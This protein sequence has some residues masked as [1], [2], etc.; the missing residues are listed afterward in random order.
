MSSLGTA[1]LAKLTCHVP[2]A[3]GWRATVTLESGEAPALGPATLTIADLA[4]PG[5]VVRSGLDAPGNPRAVLFGG[6]GWLAPLA[7][8]ASYQSA[9]G[10][11]L[12]TVLRDLATA[13]GETIV[14]PTEA[15]I[16]LAFGWPSASDATPSTG[17]LVLNRLVEDGSLATW[18]VAPTGSTRFDAWPTSRAPDARYRVVSRDLTVG[19]RRL[20]LDTQAAAFLPGATV[21]GIPIARVTFEETSGDLAACVWTT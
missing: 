4:L 18:R 20:G 2:P 1:R 14:Q 17:R 7:R 5:T 19:L 8:A 9:G 13:T 3:G 15:T 10:V 21:E 6:A 16:G 11:R 12:S